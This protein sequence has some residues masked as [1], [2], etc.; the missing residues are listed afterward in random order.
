MRRGH[1]AG[2]E[3]LLGA[4]HQHVHRAAAPVLAF[5]SQP[6]VKLRGTAD[7]EPFQE[8]PIDQR[9]CAGVIAGRCQPFQSVGVEV[10]RAGRNPHLRRVGLEVVVTRTQAQHAQGFVQGV[11][12][13]LLRL[14]A[15]QQADEMFARSGAFGRPGQ[16]NQQREVLLP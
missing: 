11:A 14:L 5:R 9:G 3:Q 4:V 12:R 10:D 7:T 13:L 16:I 15:P 8:V 6:I 1:I 2:G